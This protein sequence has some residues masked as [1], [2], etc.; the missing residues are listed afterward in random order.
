MRGPTPA[1]DARAGQDMLVIVTK[2]MITLP[3]RRDNEVSAEVRAEAFL[4]ALDDL[5][6]WAVASAVRQWHRGDC[7]QDDRGQP[8]DYHW[9]PSPAEL[10]RIAKREL[11]LRVGSQLYD[12]NRLLGAEPLIEHSDEHRASMLARFAELRLKLQTSLVGKDGSGEAAAHRHADS[13]TVG[14]GK[15][16]SPA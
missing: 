5:P 12:L 7:G 2:L 4:M 1:T 13:A 9:T 15:C 6:V 10:R 14:P 11:W 8:Y 16:A 3:A